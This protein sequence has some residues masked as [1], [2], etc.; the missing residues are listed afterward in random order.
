[1]MRKKRLTLRIITIF[2]ILIVI[3]YL[4][5]L[6]NQQ[7]TTLIKNDFFKYKKSKLLNYNYTTDTEKVRQSLKPLCTCRKDENICVHL[8]EFENYNIYHTK[9]SINISTYKMTMSEFEDSNI[10][11][12]PFH[13]LRRGRKQK[14]IS[15]SIG[16]Y[17][18][19]NVNHLKQL[20]HS[21]KHWYPDWIIRVYH[22]SNIDQS[23]ICELECFQDKELVYYDNIDFCDVNEFPFVFL[24]VLHLPARFWRWLPI[25]DSFVDTFLSRD[26]EACI[27]QRESIVVNEWMKT[28]YLFHSIR[29]KLGTVA[30]VK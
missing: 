19:L 10:V 15:Y 22:N 24:N 5:S 11:C 14:V 21:I 16:P 17:E 26:L 12:N 6:F 27:G 13:V 18:E 3:L 25:G 9:D 7:F 28:D 4:N 20:I 1:M 30:C 29:G 2:L 23:T 8:D